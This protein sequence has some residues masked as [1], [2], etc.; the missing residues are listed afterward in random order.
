MDVLNSF[1]NN[2]NS[3]IKSKINTNTSF[4]HMYKNSD[5]L[6]GKIHSTLPKMTMPKYTMPKISS[7]KKHPTAKNF[8]DIHFSNLITKDKRSHNH[9]SAP[10][11]S[12]V[13]GIVN[14]VGSAMSH[15]F[16]AITGP[17]DSKISQGPVRSSSGMYGDSW[18]NL[19][20]EALTDSQAKALL[21]TVGAQLSAGLSPDMT[22]LKQ[23]EPYMKVGA[24]QLRPT[25]ITASGI[26]STR[27]NK[28]TGFVGPG[29]PTYNLGPVHDV[30]I[31]NQPQLF[32]YSTGLY[33]KPNVNS[34]GT[35]P[36]NRLAGNTANITPVYNQYTKTL[37]EPGFNKSSGTLQYNT[38][39]MSNL[40]NNL[41]SAI[42]GSSSSSGNKSSGSSGNK[43]SGSSGSSSSS[44]SSGSSGSSKP[45]GAIGLTIVK[46]SST[47]TASAPVSKPSSNVTYS[48]SGSTY[49][50]TVSK[51]TVVSVA[52]SIVSSI[53]SGI[54]K[55]WGSLFGKK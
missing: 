52:K 5:K 54:S 4:S 34:T 45:S 12:P 7:P 30:G 16:S 9:A 40:K 25:D 28:G 49:T 6:G 26:S 1:I 29:D 42:G 55:A 27:L 17:A 19:K 8:Q 41:A 22:T 35:E 14:N 39:E 10:S 48:S 21:P 47:P 53:G 32:N 15:A 44:G 46:Q 50:A 33:G 37:I 2:K 36:V 20:V 24:V 23:L 51:P 43:S 31:Q 38:V 13:S 18:K 11:S 3:K